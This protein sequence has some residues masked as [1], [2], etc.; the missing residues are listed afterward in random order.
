MKLT[1]HDMILVALQ[2]YKGQELSYA[3]IKEIVSARFPNFNLGSLQPNDHSQ[4]GNKNC[5]RCVGSNRQ[6]FINRG[7]ATYQVL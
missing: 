5:C 3:K 4:L 7:R 2:P 6:L 1:N